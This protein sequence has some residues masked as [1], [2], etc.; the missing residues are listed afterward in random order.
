MLEQEVNPTDEG[1]FIRS[2]PFHVD[3]NPVFQ[4]RAKSQTVFVMARELL[5]RL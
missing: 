3:P 1:I 4:S 5:A 2:G